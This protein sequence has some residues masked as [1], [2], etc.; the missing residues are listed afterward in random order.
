MATV[1]PVFQPLARLNDRHPVGEEAFAR[2]KDNSAR[3]LNAGAFIEVA[4]QLKL[5]HR[6]DLMLFEAAL[7][8][9]MYPP[10]GKPRAF[11]LPITPRSLLRRRR[12]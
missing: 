1:T 8:R 4:L 5:L 12:I 7:E 3:L 11:H 6:I 2:I 9:L 10:P